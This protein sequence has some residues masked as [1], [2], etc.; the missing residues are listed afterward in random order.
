MEK[1]VFQTRLQRWFFNGGVLLL[2]FCEAI[3][4]MFMGMGEKPPVLLEVAKSLA[5]AAG[6]LTMLMFSPSERVVIVGC[7]CCSLNC[8]ELRIKASFSRIQKYWCTGSDNR[9]IMKDPLWSHLQNV[10]SFKGPTKLN[11]NNR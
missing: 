3:S 10:G 8:S 2:T 1:M 9:F 11:D 7:D 6:L 5:S 4:L